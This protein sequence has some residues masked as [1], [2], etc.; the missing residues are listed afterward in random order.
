V[1]AAGS[2]AA[3]FA[4]ARRRCGADDQAAADSRGVKPEL[5]G[6]VENE[7]DAVSLANPVV[8]LQDTA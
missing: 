7:V 5:D 8:S 3:G 1:A 2:G 4:I 6:T